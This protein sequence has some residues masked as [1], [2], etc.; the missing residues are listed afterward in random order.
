MYVRR[1]YDAD[2]T[3]SVAGR[4]PGQVVHEFDFLPTLWEEWFFI[5][6]LFGLEIT[7]NIGGPDIEGY[8]RWLRKN[9]NISPLYRPE[10]PGAYPMPTSTNDES[11]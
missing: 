10:K 4:P 1:I 3:I 2:A 5:L 6:A 7:I 8:E 9:K 11:T